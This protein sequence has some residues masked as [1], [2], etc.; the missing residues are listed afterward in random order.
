LDTKH[1]F[2]YVITFPKGIITCAKCDYTNTYH[3]AFSKEVQDNIAPD[4]ATLLAIV[5]TTQYSK[6][7]NLTSPAV[8]P[9][10]N[11]NPTITDV[12]PTIVAVNP[13]I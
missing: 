13:Q 3:L 4:T 2:N 9:A 7:T 11:I 6:K 1:P 8:N 12:N 5:A 10:T